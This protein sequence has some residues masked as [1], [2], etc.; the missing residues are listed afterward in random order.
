MNLNTFRM[1]SRNYY[2]QVED[3]RATVLKFNYQGVEIFG[4]FFYLIIK[5]LIMRKVTLGFL[6]I[7]V[8]T[9]KS[10]ILLIGHLF[11]I[12]V[13]F[14][15]Q[16]LCVIIVGSL[17]IWL[18]QCPYKTNP[19]DPKQHGYL[20]QHLE[21]SLL[22]CIFKLVQ[23]KNV[24]IWTEDVRGIWLEIFPILHHWPKLV[25]VMWPSVIIERVRFTVKVQLVTL[26]SLQMIYI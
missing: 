4:F 22:L 17:I 13:P 9:L 2:K 16:L 19:K 8:Q 6:I 3:L 7:V 15:N 26:P 12:R 24:G 14:Q 5:S 21:L 25:M 23:A 18:L 11:Q 1:K 10:E 20:Q